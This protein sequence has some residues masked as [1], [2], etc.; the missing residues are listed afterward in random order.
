MLFRVALSLPKQPAVHLVFL[1]HGGGG[2]ERK[3]ATR[4]A[5]ELKSDGKLRAYAGLPI[6]AFDAFGAPFDALRAAAPAERVERG[7][8]KPCKAWVREDVSVARG[9]GRLRQSEA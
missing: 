5:K 3:R 1:G 7:G 9:C 8:N 4:L 2:P 6:E